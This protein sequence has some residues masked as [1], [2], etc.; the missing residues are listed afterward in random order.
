MNIYYGLNVNTD[1]KKMNTQDTQE[2]SI[3]YSFSACGH[4]GNV[5]QKN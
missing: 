2:V 5:R 4:L 3:I 1:T